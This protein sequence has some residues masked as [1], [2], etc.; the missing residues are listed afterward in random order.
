MKRIL[1][2]GIN[3]Y[4]GGRFRQYMEQFPE[5]ATVSISMRDG[6]WRGEDFTGFD[7]VYHVAGLAHSD[8]GRISPEKAQKYYEINTDLTKELAKKAKSPEGLTEWEEMERAALRREYIDAV[9][10]SL[11]GQLDNTY[12]V[13]AKG[14]KT[15][16]KKKGE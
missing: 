2:T 8:N 15:K 3:S 1:I 14:N 4:L 16:L 13:D 5:Y 6:S 7:V 11:K 12:I 9:L 10:G